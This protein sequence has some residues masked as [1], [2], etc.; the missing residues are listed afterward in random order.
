MWRAISPEEIMALPLHVSIQARLLGA[1]SYQGGSYTFSWASS[2]PVTP[3]LEAALQEEI[4][5]AIRQINGLPEDAPLYA[6]DGRRI[7]P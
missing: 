5:R 3:D 7:S 1:V 2:V 6:D 4:H